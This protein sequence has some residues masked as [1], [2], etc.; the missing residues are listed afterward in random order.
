M[1]KNKTRFFSS[2]RWKIAFTYL[3]VIGIGFVVANISIIKVFEMREVNEKRERF[4][5][6]AI[7]TAQTISNKYAS[8]DVNIKADVI[9]D[10]EELGNEISYQEGRQPTRILVLD[11]NGV[12]EFD[13]YND[14]SPKVL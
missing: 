8:D 4:R 11:R 13:S 3:I 10:I 5:A 1:L 2:L 6:Y 9:Y 7:Q 12:V 14:L